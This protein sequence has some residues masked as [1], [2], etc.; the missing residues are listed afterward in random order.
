MGRIGTRTMEGTDLSVANFSTSK[1][2]QREYEVRH[3]SS[4]AM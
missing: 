1:D 2:R 3:T 4:T